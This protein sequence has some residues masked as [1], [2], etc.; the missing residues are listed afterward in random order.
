MQNPTL[1]TPTRVAVCL[2]IQSCFSVR[3]IGALLALLFFTTNTY[4][5]QPDAVNNCNELETAQY[6]T[7]GTT[8]SNIVYRLRDFTNDGPAICN[9]TSFIDGW[10]KFNSG[11]NTTVSIAGYSIIHPFP[12][13]GL[14]VYTGSCDALVQVACTSPNSEAASLLVAV[15]PNT[16]YILRIMVTSNGADEIPFGYFCIE[17][18]SSCSTTLPVAEGLNTVD[19]SCWF[20]HFVTKKTGNA[21]SLS[22]VTS[23]SSP[24]GYGPTEGSGFFQFNSYSSQSGSQTRLCSTPIDASATTA[25]DVKF[26]WLTNPSGT[27]DY[28]QVQYS[29][30]GSNWTNAGAA[31]SRIGT[32]GWKNQQV[33]ISAV[34]GQSRVFIGLLFTSS[35]SS[36]NSHVDNIRVESVGG[37]SAPSNVNSTNITASSTVL[38]WTAPA[39]STPVGYDWEIR[40][41]GQGGSGN[42]GLVASGNIV[43]NTTQASVT[44]LSPNTSY[45]LHVRTNCG[46]DNKSVWVSSSTFKTAIFCNAP[47]NLSA[48][49]ILGTTA[50]ITWNAPTSS[51]PAS[52]NWE[53][54]SS[55]IGG[56]GSAGLVNSGTTSM[57]VREA[58]IT[59]LTENST[60]NVYARSVCGTDGNSDWTGPIVITTNCI[61]RTVPWTENFD[62]VN[63]STAGTTNFPSCWKNG[64]GDWKTFSSPPLDANVSAPRS[65]NNVIA[66]LYMG[67]S[68]EDIWTPGFQLTAGTTYTFSFWYRD[69]SGNNYNWNG[70][71]MVNSAQTLSGASLV[72]TEF[73]TKTSTVFDKYVQVTKHF[74]PTISGVYYF[75]V[76]LKALDIFGTNGLTFDD[77]NLTESAACLQ[78]DFKA[79]TDITAISSQLNWGQPA[80][81]S[82][83]YEWEVRNTNNPGSGPEGLKANGSTLSGIMSANASPLSPNQTYGVYARSNCGAAGYSAWSGPIRL[84]TPDVLTVGTIETYTSIE[85]ASITGTALKGSINNT[86]MVVKIPV[87]GSATNNKLTLTNIAFQANNTADNSVP[88][89][90]AKLWTGTSSAPTTLIAL[91]TIASGKINFNGLSLN[92]TAGNNYLWLTYDVKN[93]ALEGHK[94]AAL[95]KSGDIVISSTGGANTGG[96]QPHSD[97]NHMFSRFI[98]SKEY[99]KINMDPSSFYSINN[100]RVTGP[101][102]SSVINNASDLPGT[103]AWGYDD[104]FNVKGNVEQGGTYNF[105]ID[106]NQ[107]V[108]GNSLSIW[109]DLNQDGDFSDVGERLYQSSS[110]NSS[111]RTGSFVIPTTTALGQTTLRIIFSDLSAK[112]NSTGCG[113]FGWGQVED[114]QLQ[115]AAP[116]CKQPQAQPIA[117]VL[118]PS[119]SNITGSYTPAANTDGYLVIRTTTGTAPINPTDGIVYTSGTNMLGGWIEYVGGNTSF[120]STQELMPG[121]NYWFWIYSFNNNNCSAGPKYLTTTPLTAQTSTPLD[122]DADALL[123]INNDNIQHFVFNSNDEQELMV[124]NTCR[125]LVRVKPCAGLLANN[126]LNVKLW[127]DTD[128]RLFKGKF[129]VP[130]RYEFTPEIAVEACTS[131]LTLYYSQNDFDMFNEQ[132]GT[133]TSVRLPNGPD[134]NFGKTNLRV[135]QF[136]GA[137]GEETGLPESYPADSK[138]TLI[139]PID[140]NIIWNSDLQRWEV[141]F[142]I[143]GFSTFIVSNSGLDVLPVKIIGFTGS[144]KGDSVLLQWHTAM[145]DNINRYLIQSSKNG[146]NFITVGKQP[147]I[148]SGTNS[149]QFKT[150]NTADFFRIVALG[151]DETETYSSTIKIH[152]KST[153]KYLLYPTPATDY[154]VLQSSDVNLL[155]S[156]AVVTDM[157]GKVLHKIIV[158]NLPLTIPIHSLSS[159]LYLLQ[160]NNKITLKIIKQ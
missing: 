54:R 150:A 52:Y 97:L 72:G 111:S 89:G 159:G 44:T 83:G 125:S 122:C 58:L 6:L 40:T 79:P 154:I 17:G 108:N 10:Y 94:L 119:Q 86:I 21:A 56:S 146:T 90:A 123:G 85:S 109:A 116:T 31:I 104:F 98:K 73:L 7:I 12:K 30:D 34:A 138:K 41:S 153:N 67:S 48:S 1:S 49:E 115:V 84:K 4:G 57:D 27:A 106:F 152:Y 22:Y 18:R 15:Q 143:Q 155:G 100:V 157:Q 129:Y 133:E 14:A 139:D 124:P 63:T 91:A 95:V 23:S 88:L 19:A 29:L 148:G 114:Y 13:L 132:A 59:S 32:A 110:F 101:A 62:N 87:S 145:E 102:S 24:S 137:S 160:L 36:Q 103:V 126:S 50:K 68:D 28:V 60:F 26:D 107:R 43:G 147:S 46:D 113:T 16:D 2:L 134:D 47:V 11:T 151:N 141:T 8:C 149:Y 66:N 93:D 65:G 81:N 158:T 39:S 144:Q 37:C 112:P 130:R 53:V 96:S 127:V 92:L 78:P 120:L 38:N 128:L 76:V 82:L 51:S 35:A 45:Q 136:H 80:S 74:T 20:K 121:T 105:T 156:V 99:C 142:E 140:D 71:I 42:T 61:S 117:L 69:K 75:G 9:G 55:G 118:T 70:R 5:Q 3:K 64:N 131:T 77:F 25:L 135:Y 33:S